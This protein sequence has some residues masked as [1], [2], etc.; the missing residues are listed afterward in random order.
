MRR[1]RD[2]GPPRRLMQGGASALG[3]HTSLTALCSVPWVGTQAT[4]FPIQYSLYN[5]PKY[6][7][8]GSP[9]LLPLACHPL[10]PLHGSYGPI[11]LRANFDLCPEM[12]ERSQDLDS[13]EKPCI[14]TACVLGG[15]KPSNST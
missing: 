7:A 8:S 10:P 11:S 3:L 9:T 12:S 4:G 6:A 15:R 13:G 1:D 14:P 2:Q 5:E